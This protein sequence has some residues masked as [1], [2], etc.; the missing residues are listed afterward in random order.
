LSKKI[1]LESG[2]KYR[3]ECPRAEQS[4]HHSPLLQ[5]FTHRKPIKTYVVTGFFCWHAWQYCLSAAIKKL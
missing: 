2:K 4:G 1:L 3:L 5:L